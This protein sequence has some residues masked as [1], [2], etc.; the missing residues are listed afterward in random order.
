MS[1][2][3]FV[4]AHNIRS[5][6]NVGSI[7]RTA[8]AFGVDKIYLTGYTGTP[9][10]PRL[11]KTALGA[12]KTV[13]WEYC[14]QFKRAFDK[15]RQQGTQIVALENNVPNVIP[16]NKFK[17]KFPLALL[18]GEEVKGIKKDYLALCD[19]IVEI[20]M[21]GKKESL[22]VSVVFGIAAYYIKNCPN[23]SRWTFKN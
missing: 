19:K 13:N 3:F 8:D 23:F 20:P 5:L 21:Q 9:K 4:I 6:Y 12:E 14:K 11:Q 10:N 2:K 17:P 22:N 7:F 16:L 15:L 18:L 1:E